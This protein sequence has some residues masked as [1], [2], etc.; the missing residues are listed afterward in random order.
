MKHTFIHLGCEVNIA[1]SKVT[2][3][4]PD[5]SLEKITLKVISDHDTA[6]EFVKDYIALSIVKQ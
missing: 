3:Y 4:K 2:I 5:G 6:E 1:G